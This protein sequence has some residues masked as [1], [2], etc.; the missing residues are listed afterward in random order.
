MTR[1]FLT[2]TTILMLTAA[3]AMAAPC[4]VGTTTNAQ[5]KASSGDKSSNVD[6]GATKPVTPGAKA[7][8]PGT[9]GA[10][11]Q[12]GA[13]SEIKDGEKKPEPGKVVKQGD[14]C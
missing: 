6:P 10:M 14:D 9:V 3:T 11:S 13:G 4:A 8:S 12:V 7:E 1:T 2:A 5:G